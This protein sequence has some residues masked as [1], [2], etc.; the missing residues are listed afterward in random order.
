MAI[1][2][3]QLY[4]LELFATEHKDQTETGPHHHHHYHPHRYLRNYLAEKNLSQKTFTGTAYV[5]G[6]QNQ[7]IFAAQNVHIYSKHKI[8]PWEK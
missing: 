8:R 4:C 3:S 2:H 1:A 5:E 7:Y 6:R